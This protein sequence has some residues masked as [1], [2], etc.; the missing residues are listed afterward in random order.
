MK[1][2]IIIKWCSIIYTCFGSF[3]RKKMVSRAV[4]E[5]CFSSVFFSKEDRFHIP[6]IKCWCCLQNSEG[7][8]WVVLTSMRVS[9]KHLVQMSGKYFQ[10]GGKKIYIFKRC[11]K[12]ENSRVLVFLEI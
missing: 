7:S 10:W 12:V 6:V 11:R 1:D 8:D 3:G 9:N 5:G 2:N 4:R